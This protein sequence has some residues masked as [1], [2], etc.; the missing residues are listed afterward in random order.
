MHD[1]QGTPAHPKPARATAIAAIASCY[2]AFAATAGCRIR[3]RGRR[4]KE[5]V[6]AGRWCQTPAARHL[7]EQVKTSDQRIFASP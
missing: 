3:S 1:R 4:A 5:S 2:D 6:D 7:G